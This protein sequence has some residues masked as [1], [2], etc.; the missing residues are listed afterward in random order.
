[1]PGAPTQV[2]HDAADPLL[3]RGLRKS[4]GRLEV[5]RGVDLRLP[6]GTVCGLLGLNGAGKTTALRC[7]LGLIHRDGGEVS[8][9]GCDPRRIHRTR[10][11]VGAVF[12]ESCLHGNLTVR[13]SL[14]HARLISGDRRVRS[15]AE[16]EALLGLEP[17]RSV[18]VRK[19]SRGNLRR[20]NIAAA[21]VSRPSLLVLD[22]PFAGLD[23]G[24][25]DDVLALIRRLHATEGTS[26]L[27]ASHQLP[28]LEGIC[29]HV[30]ILHAGTVAR[31]GTMTDVLEGRRTRL[32]LRTSD[33]PRA[34][35]M[36]ARRDAVRSA[37]LRPDGRIEAE[38]DDDP[39]AINRD[40]VGAGF[41][42]S[43]LTSSPPSLEDVFREVTG[44]PRP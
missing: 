36:L 38:T 41:A 24:G 21:L 23:A 27:V 20:A 16:L 19:L 40:L 15:P 39:A 1:M 11:G 22:E 34:V 43:E 12:D 17:F 37:T 29:G 2:L 32:T 7:I 28:Y 10:G 26:V 8:V 42:V 4:F 31:S 6:R 13:Q 35:E 44:R 3:V 33:P 25:V 18:K 9:L 30:S 14:D 5:L